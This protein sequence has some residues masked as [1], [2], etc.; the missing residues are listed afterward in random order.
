M[1]L[2]T[3]LEAFQWMESFVGGWAEL[4]DLVIIKYNH[5]DARRP[6]EWMLLKPVTEVSGEVG[7]LR[8]TK[9]LDLNL[10]T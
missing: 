5:H 4:R 9:T 6:R 8:I 7:F 2:S 3:P 1:A 10:A